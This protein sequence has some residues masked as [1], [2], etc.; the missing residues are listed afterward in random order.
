V[1]FNG[2]SEG[3]VFEVPEAAPEEVLLELEAV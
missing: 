1:R 3:E 2:Q